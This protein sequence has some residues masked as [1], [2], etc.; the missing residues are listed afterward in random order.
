MRRGEERR[1]EECRGGEKRG[2]EKRREERERKGE[3]RTCHQESSRMNKDCY[4]K[5][6]S[7]TYM[8]RYCTL[9]PHNLF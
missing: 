1:R 3:E 5:R 8:P 7:Y 4:K 9:H 6:S 2:E